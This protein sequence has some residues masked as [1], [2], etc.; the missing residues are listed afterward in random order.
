MF[1][2]IKND[3]NNS[4]KLDTRLIFWK[5]MFL[6]S[7]NWG[8][9][10]TSTWLAESFPFHDDRM[11]GAWTPQESEH[12]KQSRARLRLR[13]CSRVCMCVCGRASMITNARERLRVCLCELTNRSVDAEWANCLVRDISLPVTDVIFQVLRDLRLVVV[14]VVPLRECGCLAWLCLARTYLLIIRD[15]TARQIWYNY[16]AAQQIKSNIHKYNVVYICT[17]SKNAAVYNNQNNNNNY[18]R[19]SLKSLESSFVFVKKI[20][21]HTLTHTSSDGGTRIKCKVNSKLAGSAGTQLT[22]RN[23]DKRNH[24]LTNIRSIVWYNGVLLRLID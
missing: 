24:S 5:I 21:T 9:Y 7:R 1:T 11:F 22:H 17:K 12:S 14:V 15:T 13:V 2:H 6:K 4:E 23:A 19:L 20:H 3:R 16:K 10:H 8:S 18:N